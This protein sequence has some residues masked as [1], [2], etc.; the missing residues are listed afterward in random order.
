[1]D[2]FY[3]PACNLPRHSIALKH[4]SRKCTRRCLLCNSGDIVR[5]RLKNVSQTYDNITRAISCFPT[6]CDVY[7]PLLASLCKTCLTVGWCRTTGRKCLRR[8]FGIEQDPV[9]WRLFRD[10]YSAFFHRSSL[11]LRIRSS[12][13]GPFEISGEGNVRCMCRVRFRGTGNLIESAVISPAR[14]MYIRM[15]LTALPFRSTLTAG[16]DYTV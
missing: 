7:S 16:I 3:P 15:L 1:M 11:L 8:D 5:L 13:V 10:V 9:A 14:S 2:L 12:V 4:Q 6:S